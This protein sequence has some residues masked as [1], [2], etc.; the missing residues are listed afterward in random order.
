MQQTSSIQLVDSD[1]L[2]AQVDA[3]I[4]ARMLV[5]ADYARYIH[6]RGVHVGELRLL[7]GMDAASEV[8]EMPPLFRLPGAPAGVKGLVNRHGRVVP[9]LDL[10][11]LFGSTYE[12]T[13]NAWL[14]VYGRGDE[15]VGLMI[16]SLP[17]RR[18]FIGDDQIG[19]AEITHPIAVYAKAAYRDGQ[20]IWID[21]DMEKLF[22]AVFQTDPDEL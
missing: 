8:V 3:E 10:L 13:S 2:K 17:D 11:A 15:A 21:L 1:A 14:L 19:I 12:R 6:R 7:V 16:D 4:A 5:E 20:D 9:V 22:A 18:K